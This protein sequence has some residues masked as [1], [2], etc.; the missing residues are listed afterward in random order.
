[1]A[2]LATIVVAF[3]AFAASAAA[4]PAPEGVVVEGLSDPR[5]IDAITNRAMLVAE[6]G[7]GSIT[8][9]QQKRKGGARVSTFASFPVDPEG[10]GPVDVASK[11]LRKTWVLAAGN[12]VRL[13]RKG[14][15][16]LTVDIPAYQ[17]GDPDP[18][19]LEGLPEESNP[20]G[21]ALL[22]GGGVL[23]ADAAGN[24][25][26]LLD[27]GKSL[28]TVARFKPELVPWPAGLPFGPPPG[29]PEP[30]EPVP[31]A[32]AIGPDGAWYV[33]E[34]KGFP[35]V[36]GTSRI[37]RVEPGST[38]AVCDP[39]SP[40]T[41][42]CRTVATGFT[43]VIDLGFGPDGTM[44]VLEIAKESLLGVEF[45]GAPP[46]G[47]LWA[48]E[49]GTK[50][51]LAEGELLAPGGVDAGPNGSLVVTTGTV[52]GPGAGGVVRIDP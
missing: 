30:A 37:W 52:F 5:G 46:I 4:R 47:A 25:L 33:S 3:A 19:D 31:T 18:D 23:V 36:K 12:L 32:V 29:T 45:F 49:G 43:S 24:D 20:N 17:E 41:G 16:N 40:D 14:R 44:Y 1:M 21:L 35:F 7:S 22:R 34:L 2:A 13:D 8:L 27:K 38:N 15:V 42:P 28:S 50:T 9:V 51:E 48:V 11:G 10:G 26:L 39:E 6:S